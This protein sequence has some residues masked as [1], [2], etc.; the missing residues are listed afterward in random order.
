MKVVP[1]LFYRK[2]TK[3]TQDVNG[4]N[5][6]NSLKPMAKEAPET[7]KIWVQSDARD[8]TTNDTGWVGL[9]CLE[10]AV[11]TLKSIPRSILLSKDKNTE[12]KDIEDFKS[13]DYTN[14]ETFGN[15]FDIA[16]NKRNKQGEKL[17]I[18]STSG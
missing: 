4:D 7:I 1:P 15:V 9:C 13:I 3:T 16:L 11:T 2:K 5:N 6:D 10:A 18:T 14:K 8:A 17:N 12:I